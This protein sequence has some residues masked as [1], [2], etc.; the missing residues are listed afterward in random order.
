MEREA[1][2]GRRVLLEPAGTM[3]L[4]APLVPAEGSAAQRAPADAAAQR[5]LADAAA[6][7][8]QAVNLRELP[9]Q[10]ARRGWGRGAL[11]LVTR[12]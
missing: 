3:D 11:A 8:E 4:A 10:A 1:V 7:E 9:V 5:E 6:R 12:G 2:V